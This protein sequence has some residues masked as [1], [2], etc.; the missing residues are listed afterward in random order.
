[1]KKIEVGSAVSDSAGRVDGALRVGWLP[2]GYPMETPV[3]IVRGPEDGPVVWLHGCVHGNEYCG[4]FVIHKFLRELDAK[5]LR[6]TVVALP[7]LNITDRKSV[8]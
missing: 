3:V 2:D 5:T 6:G 1:M 7:A 8:V 4:A